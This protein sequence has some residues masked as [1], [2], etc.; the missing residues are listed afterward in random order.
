VGGRLDRN[1][2]LSGEIK[3]REGRHGKTW[4]DGLNM[5]KV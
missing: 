5:F 1:E 3:N 2:D 4:E